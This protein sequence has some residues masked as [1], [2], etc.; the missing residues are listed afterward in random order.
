MINALL[1]FAMMQVPP[2]DTIEVR[3]PVTRQQVEIQPIVLRI[4][5]TAGMDST[6]IQLMREA[7]AA[8]AE[9]AV[10]DYLIACGCVEG[11][12]GLSWWFELGTLG[13]LAWAIYEYKHKD[14]GDVN[15]VVNEGDTN[16]DV[17]VDNDHSRPPGHHKDR[18]HGKS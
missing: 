16:V 1:L 6:T 11:D 13:L 14:P 4:E 12:S 5:A 9:G 17:D 8:S 18:K 10:A 2:V 3:V 15:T 7:A